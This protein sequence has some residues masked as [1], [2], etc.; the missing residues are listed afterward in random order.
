MA[1]YLAYA[2][3]GYAILDEASQ[4]TSHTG[5]ID[6]VSTLGSNTIGDRPFIRQ[7]DLR[8][9]S[10]LATY[11]GNGPGRRPIPHF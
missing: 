8:L 10:G 9:E 4:Q 11:K 3:A 2:T 7:Q 5:H 6:G 1:V